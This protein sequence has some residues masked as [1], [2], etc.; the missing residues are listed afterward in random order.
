MTL[1][2]LDAQLDTGLASQQE[3]NKTNLLGGTTGSDRVALDVEGAQASSLQLL[4]GG[5]QAY[6]AAGGWVQAAERKFI[7]TDPNFQLEAHWDELKEGVPG[8]YYD[9]FGTVNSLSEARLLKSQIIEEVKNK[10]LLA[11]SGVRGAVAAGLAGIVDL[12]APLMFASGGT[13]LGTKL[14]ALTAKIGLA[15]TR[16]EQIVKAG[17]AGVEAGLIT[18]T[19]NVLSRPTGDWTDIPYAGLSGLVFGAG[20]GTL[21]KTEAKANAAASKLRGDFSESVAGREAGR[22]DY[23][24]GVQDDGLFA[25]FSEG[26]VGAASVVKPTFDPGMVSED[27]LKMRQDAQKFIQ[28]NG[29]AMQVETAFPNTPQGRAAQK[30]HDALA[31][32]ILASDWDK[33]MKSNSAIAQAMAYK[34]FESPAGIVRNNKSGAMLHEIYHSEIQS[35]VTTNYTKHYDAW[36]RDNSP[37]TSKLVNRLDTE[38]SD[39]FNQQIYTELQFRLHD[40]VSSPNVHP[41]VKTY[42]DQIDTGSATGIKVLQ[43]LSGETPVRGAELL[44]AERGWFPQRWRG[45]KISKLIREKGVSRQAIEKA[46]ANSYT[47]LYPTWDAEMAMTYAKAVT[48]RSLAKENGIDTNLFRLLDQEGIEYMQQFLRDNG[49]TAARADQLIEGLKG[50]KA[51]QSKENILKSRKDVDLRDQIPGTDY[52]LMDLVDTDIIKVW[53]TYSRQA[54]GAAAMARHGI[55]KADKKQFMN[56]IMAEEHANGGST[57]SAEFVQDMFSYFEGGGFAGGLNPW[58]R[59]AMQT[60]NLA[61]LNGLG[62][63]QAAEVGVQI[64]AVGW[65]AFM[66]TAPKEVKD[67]LSGKT[68]EALAD[69]RGL[70]AGIDGEHNIHMDWMALDHMRSDPGVMRELGNFLDG[71]LVKGSQLQGY[72]SGFFKMKQLQQRIAVRSMLY[73]LAEHFNGDKA[74]GKERLYDLGITN[75]TIHNRIGKYFTDGTVELA[76]DGDVLKMNFDKWKPEDVYEI[77]ASLNRHVN[78]V[79]QKMLRGESTQWFHRDFG[80]FLT[81]LKTFTI[82]AIQKQLLRNARIQDAESTMSFIYS[83]MT[84]GA[85]YTA[86]QVIAGRDQ[87]LTPE[88]IIKGSIQMSNMTGFLP[89]WTDPVASM[90]G[91]DSLRFSP[92]N[93]QGVSGDVLGPPPA[94]T[95]LNRMAHIPGSALRVATGDYKNQ[96]VY[97]LQATPI[98]GN[99]YGFSY[100]FNKMKE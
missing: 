16:V 31:S 54:S 59:R 86:Q 38:L 80:A 30:M 28:K 82:G 69:F 61:L 52:R 94:L 27:V 36:T 79:V 29:I 97:A 18:E 56:A 44:K 81:H 83:L 13:Y 57:L 93:A 70:I 5:F 67:M 88:R 73:R 63:T 68:N 1:E 41:A 96:D 84:A 66:K 20:I 39:R 25:K 33:L 64:G 40:G 3:A 22:T 95:T 71:L 65:E 60:T 37:N 90:L 75:E 10:R 89:Q 45:D 53:S 26:S 76:K 15:G 2:E 4:E 34:L 19:G 32:T 14:G 92:Y 24:S 77:S 99:L 50:K 23:S 9:Q 51:D 43:G 100:M 17:A 62:L 72:T 55:Q 98:I 91:L 58:V 48:R 74:I 46:L 35:P 78:Q 87:N 85:V 7:A 47:K 21:T 49:F 12:D 6:N 8:E 11:H 42:V